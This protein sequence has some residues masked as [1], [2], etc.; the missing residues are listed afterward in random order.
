[1]WILPGSHHFTPEEL[2][3]LL[4]AFPT[5]RCALWKVSGDVKAEET[6]LNQYGAF[7]AYPRLV[8]SFISRCSLSTNGEGPLVDRYYGNRI[9]SDTAWLATESLDE[10]SGFLARTRM[11][12]NSAVALLE[13]GGTQEVVW[14]RAM[15]LMGSRMLV[16]NLVRKSGQFSIPS[17][18]DRER[19]LSFFLTAL[20]LSVHILPFI[21]CEDSDTKRALVV[22]GEE[23]EIKEA[24]LRLSLSSEDIGEKGLNHWLARGAQFLT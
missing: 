3:L 9:Y 6:L 2:G 4:G 7:A 16:G 12:T 13:P 20:C 10:F 22:W 5:R 11:F 15:Q 19:E 14:T 23:H 17:L 24:A 21:A 8:E 18:E 1:L